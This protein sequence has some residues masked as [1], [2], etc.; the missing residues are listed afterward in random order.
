MFRVCESEKGRCLIAI[1]HI[2]ANTIV[3]KES[4]FLVAEDAYDAIYKLYCNEAEDSEEDSDDSKQRLAFES[5]TPYELDKYVISYADIKAEISTLPSYVQE[6]L[7]Y[8]PK[9]KMRLL[10]AKFYRNAF[11]YPCPPC[12]LLSTG[13]LMNHS[14]DNNI[15]FH[16]DKNGYFVFTANRDIQK[17]EE[18]CDSYLQTYT[19]TKKRRGSLLSQYGFTCQCPKC[20]RCELLKK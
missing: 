6:A 4:P 15:D 2:K 17:G 20:C 1:C 7:S 16:V 14:C 8:I 3:I 5:L 10:V 9:A 18:L 12:A 13:T 11:T 19:S